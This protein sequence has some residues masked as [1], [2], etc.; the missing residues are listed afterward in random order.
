MLAYFIGYA[1]SLKTKCFKHSRVFQP[2]LQRSDQD[3]RENTLAYNV[4]DPKRFIALVPGQIGVLALGPQRGSDLVLVLVT[5]LYNF[6]SSSLVRW[7]NKLVCLFLLSLSSLG[8]VA[9]TFLL[10]Q[11]IMQHSKLGCL[12]KP[13][14]VTDNNK[15][16]SLLAWT[17]LQPQLMLQ[18]S[19]LLCLSKPIK[20]TDK[21]KGINLLCFRLY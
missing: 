13:V 12:S 19:K 10:P 8:S 18:H 3:S 11:L 14:K 15:A 16:I 2:Y 9:Q 17:F 7:P 5:R 6:F 20:V 1:R 4:Q 21:N